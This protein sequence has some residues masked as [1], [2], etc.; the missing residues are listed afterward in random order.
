M[1]HQILGQFD[2]LQTNNLKTLA[3][4]TASSTRTIQFVT[5]PQCALSS[6]HL[7]LVIIIELTRNPEDY[8]PRAL[9]ILTC[10]RRPDILLTQQ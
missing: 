8:E 3:D 6:A 7:Q 10:K 5:R 9:G 2:V 1:T 4:T